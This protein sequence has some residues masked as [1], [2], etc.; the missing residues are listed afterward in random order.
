MTDDDVELPSA[1]PRG[2]RW[3]GLACV[4]VPFVVSFTTSNTR[5][6]NGAVVEAVHHNW[7]ALGGGG[8]GLVLGLAVLGL[9]LRAPAGAK[10]KEL[11]LGAVIVALALVQL[12]VRSGFVL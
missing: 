3:F 10:A 11:A 12:V 7:V 1:R 4:L 8:L 2:L 6:T 9:A 5:T